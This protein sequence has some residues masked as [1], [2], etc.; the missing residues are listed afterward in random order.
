MEKKQSLGWY[1]LQSFVKEKGLVRQHLDSYESF[2]NSLMQQ[3]V[4]YYRE[5]VDVPGKNLKICFGKISVDTDP[6]L[7]EADRTMITE[8]DPVQARIRNMDYSLPLMLEIEIR[9]VSRRV[10]EEKKPSV[11]RPVLAMGP[12]AMPTT[13]SCQAMGIPIV[14]EKV[15]I[16]RLPVM[17]R[18]SLCPLSSKTREELISMG[19]DPDDPGG[20]FIIAGSE[21]VIVSQ[22][23]LV[24]NKILVDVAP[25]TMPAQ[26]M[27]KVFSYYNG[28]RSPVSLLLAKDG[29]MLVESTAFPVRIPFAVLMKALGVE[30]DSQIVNLVSNSQEIQD[31]LLVPLQ[32]A[33]D[34][35]S[36]EAALDYIGGRLAVGQPRDIRIRRAEEQ[37]DARFMPH[38]GT[39]PEDR[40]RKAVH[41]ALMAE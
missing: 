14:R 22:E 9:D 21:R 28:I 20:Y 23:D 25:S 4:D 34:I 36:K 26:Y 1:A 2:L 6:H 8:L 33:S 7:I 17:L 39:S 5:G 31:S 27:A 30:K 29:K 10:Q 3:V 38:L 19:E 32:D 13:K 11:E 37:I 12:S 41:L 24:S 15:Y 40:L 35:T 18:S 16:G